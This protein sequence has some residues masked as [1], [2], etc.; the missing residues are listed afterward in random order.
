MKLY[1][2]VRKGNSVLTDGLCSFA[3]SPNVNPRDYRL[4]CGSEDRD[5]IIAWMESCFSGRSRGIRFFTETIKPHDKAQFVLGEFVKNRDLFSID[6]QQLADDGLVEG[7]YV[8]PS[9][10]T[11]PYY[12]FL[13]QKGCDELLIKLDSVRDI[14]F[15]PID[16]SVCDD[17]QGRRFAFV[18]YY[19]IIVKGGVIPPRYICREHIAF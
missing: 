7:V 19:L 2:Y 17:E 3:T 5:D 13:A 18:R 11:S 8:S 16:W 4:R 1:H 14:D 12:A 6:I 10:M 15:S 9:V